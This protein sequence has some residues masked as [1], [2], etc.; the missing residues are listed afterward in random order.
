[1]KQI[2]DAIDDKKMARIEGIIHSM[3]AKERA[4]PALI[5]PS[6]KRRIAAGAGVDIAEVN[7]LV[8]QFE[9]AKK[10]MKSM[11]GFGGKGKRGGKFGNFK[12][13]F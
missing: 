8:K 5:N 13:P 11:S 12:L 1:M 3:T 4:N 7:R 2:E 6:R 10:M 9:Q